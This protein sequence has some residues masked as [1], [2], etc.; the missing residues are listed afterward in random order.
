MKSCLVCDDHPMM[1]EALAGTIAMH[2]PDADV[3]LAG[4]FPAA[5]AAAA[6]QPDIILCDLGMPGATPLHG[7]VA[8]AAAAP[9]AQLVV[10]T[11][12]VSDDLLKALFEAGI[13]GLIPK[14]SSGAVMEAA[15]RLVLAGG[16][17][18]P[19][20]IIAMVAAAPRAH[21]NQLRLSDRQVEVLAKIAAGA[22]NKEIARAMQLSPATVKAQVAALLAVLGA[23][24][25]I[26]ATARG[27]ALNYID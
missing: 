7:V 14:A 20:R 13:A 25:R 21:A 22:S 10:I 6:A 19:P 18:L 5:W 2:W 4:D 15:I 1:R 23:G 24:N 9:G 17:Y 26:E 16:R 11:A 12:D 8:L 3:A 27:R